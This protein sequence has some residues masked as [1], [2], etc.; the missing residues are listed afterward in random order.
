MIER[1]QPYVRQLHV[2]INDRKGESKSCG[3]DGSEEIVEELR[4]VSKGRNLKGKVRV[5]RS[6][7]LDVCAFGP[8]MMI[9]PEGLWFMRVTK[10]D[11]PQI[12]EKYLSLEAAEQPK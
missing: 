3:Y 5:V 4:T 9:W 12:V 7:C 1:Q 8:N 2:C 10:E 6:G 11:V